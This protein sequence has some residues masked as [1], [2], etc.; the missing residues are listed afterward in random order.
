MVDSVMYSSGSELWRTP[1][2]LVA[3]LE[4][5]L[6]EFDLDPCASDES[7]AKAK[8]FL[9]PKQDGLKQ[10]WGQNNFVNPPWRRAN[11]KKG[12]TAIPIMPWIR[13]AVME[14]GQCTL[15][16]AA[17]TDTDF[18]RLAFEHAKLVMFIHGRLLYLNENNQPVFPAAFPSVVL[19]TEGGGRKPK[20]QHTGLIS[21]TGE[22]LV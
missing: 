6:G 8:R 7:A 14:P 22:V 1:P 21:R 12:I 16:L 15:L 9:T 5:L 4:L 18:F 11:K 2:E 19:V 10:P 13:K 20:T 17:R 3:G